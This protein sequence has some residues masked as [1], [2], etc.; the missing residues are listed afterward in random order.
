LVIGF[1]FEFLDAKME[2]WSAGVQ[3]G[4]AIVSMPLKASL[5]AA[6]ALFPDVALAYKA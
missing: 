6:G 1:S 2:I 5:K 4:Q 3:Y